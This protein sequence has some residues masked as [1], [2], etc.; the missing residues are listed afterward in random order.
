MGETVRYFDLPPDQV[1]VRIPIYGVVEIVSSPPEAGESPESPESAVGNFLDSQVEFYDALEEAWRTVQA[2]QQ[3]CKTVNGSILEAKEGSGPPRSTRRFLGKIAREFFDLNTSFGMCKFFGHQLYG[4]FV[5]EHGEKDAPDTRY[6]AFADKLS[7]MWTQE[8]EIVKEHFSD[9]SDVSQTFMRDRSRAQTILI[10]AYM[11]AEFRQEIALNNIRSFLSNSNVVPAF[12]QRIE[13]LASDKSGEYPGLLELLATHVEQDGQN[14]MLL[15]AF[16]RTSPEP[17]T[18]ADDFLKSVEDKREQL[19]KELSAAFGVFNVM[20]G[21]I[22]SEFSV[23]RQD[24]IR[25][26]AQKAASWPVELLNRLNSYAAGKSNER[27][28]IFR[29]ALSP[30]V[31]KGRLVT[32]VIHRKS[33]ITGRQPNTRTPAVGKKHQ[34]TTTRIIQPTMR[35]APGASFEDVVGDQEREPIDHYAVLVSSGDRSGR[36]FSL[37]PVE[38]LEELYLFSNLEG[39][40]SK[41]NSDPTV[42]DVIDAAIEHLRTNPTDRAHTRRLNSVVYDIIGQQQQRSPLRFSPQHFPGISKGPIATKTRLIYDV[43]KFNNSPT[44]VVYGAF[45]KQDIERLSAMPRIR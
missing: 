18:F 44:L 34:G 9:T 15:E 4:D 7:E 19:P 29:E 13:S 25:L 40:I 41:Y 1:A 30:Y 14:N 42:R 20:G 26:F 10:M 16:R 23:S 21:I 3:H 35:T 32:D 5:K 38:N 27:W 8:E 37:E 28:N 31:R 36:R 22:E 11:N 6:E 12:L 2:G 45:I 39:Y 24:F 43:M 17:A 33:S